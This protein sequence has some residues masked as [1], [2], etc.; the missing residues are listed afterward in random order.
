MT[1]SQPDLVGATRS[2]VRLDNQMQNVTVPTPV[3]PRAFRVAASHTTPPLTARARQM[4]QRVTLHLEQVV[5]SNTAPT[6]DVFLNLPVGADPNQHEDRFVARVSMFGIK[7]AS[8]PNGVHGG[9]G[10]NFAFDITE[11]YHRLD[12]LNQIDQANLK[13]TFVPVDPVGDQQVNVG[14]VSLYFA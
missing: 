13:V 9:G 3:T 4:V 5:S 1:L 8:D 14:R 7:Q 6:Y 10:Q 11:L 2:A 12:D